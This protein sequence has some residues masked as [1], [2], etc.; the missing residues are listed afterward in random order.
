MDTPTELGPYRLLE[1]IG[2]GGMGV[3]WKA[4]HRDTGELAAV[5]TVR[6][7]SAALIETIRREVHALSQL[8]HPGIVRVRESGVRLDEPWYAMDWVDGS[9]PFAEGASTSEKIQ[10]D[11]TW[12]P[13][14]PLVDTAPTSGTAAAL[15]VALT[16][17]WRLCGP[18]AYLHG[19]GA[20]H[21]DL[22]PGNVLLRD[23]WP[24]IVDFGLVERFGGGTREALD[25]GGGRAFTPRYAAPEQLRGERVDARADLYALGVM[26]F[27]LVAGELPFDGSSSEIVDQHLHAAPPLLSSRVAGVPDPLDALVLGLLAKNPRRRLGHADDVAAELASLGADTYPWADAPQSKAYLYRPALAGRESA[28]RTLAQA[29]RAALVGE[30]GVGKTRL[31]VE[32]AQRAEARGALVVSGVGRPGGSAPF[33]LWRRPLDRLAEVCRERGE[34]FT[35]EVLAERGAVLADLRP[36]IASLRAWPP[37]P[38]LRGTAARDRR[39]DAVARTWDAFAARVPALLV[40]DDVQWADAMSIDAAARLSGGLLATWRSE[41]ASVALEPLADACETISLGPLTPDEVRAVVADMLGVAEAPE[42]FATWL[43]DRCD[44]MPFFVAEYLDLALHEGLLSRDGRGRWLLG[45]TWDSQLSELAL[46]QLPIPRGLAELA[47][48]RTDGLS[49]DARS[50]LLAAAVLAAPVP[51]DALGELVRLDGEDLLDAWAPLERRRLLAPEGDGEVGFVHDRLRE[52]LWQ[53]VPPATRAYLHRRAAALLEARSEDVLA[54]GGRIGRHREHAGQPELARTHY[55]AAGQHAA[56]RDAFAEA[57]E[58][59]EQAIALYPADDEA[60]VNL[61]Y[62]LG[63]V[64]ISLGRPKDAVTVG[65]QAQAAATARGDAHARMLARM[66][67]GQGLR[68]LGRGDDAD[69]ALE[70]ALED[71]DHASPVERAR[72][73]HL[74]ALTRFDRGR[75]DEALARTHIALDAAREADEPFLIAAIVGNQGTFAMHTGDY[76]LAIPALT[77]AVAVFRELNAPREA[78]IFL[79]NLGTVYSMRGELELALSHFEEAVAV[80]ERVGDARHAAIHGGNIALTHYESGDLDA[81]DTGFARAVAAL[82]EQ[83]DPYHLG[84]YL[85]SWALVALDQGDLDTART[86]LQASERTQATL[87]APHAAAQRHIIASA[88]A[89]A[90]GEA[91]DEHEQRVREAAAFF[92]DSGEGPGASLAWSELGLLRLARGAAADDALRRAT[93]AAEAAKVRLDGHSYVAKWLRALQGQMATR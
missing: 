7:A 85:T 52:A 11:L 12:S 87:D 75:F 6:V 26:L 70:A 55:A 63:T 73:L 31:A 1:Q 8:A 50:L 39:V 62:R 76:D 27:E 9:Q 81:A 25:L 89:R 34:A 54:D 14:E 41:E 20:V 32:A 24:V 72:L 43:A 28:L 82:E 42:P 86:R 65:E 19:E 17:I 58:L 69:A 30:G 57:A 71:A 59:L 84:L 91:L 2:A 35:D 53:E 38:P 37:A 23:G 80:A 13:D 78:G 10:A 46:E 40:L 3:V 15:D 29:P 68:M 67:L 45:G 56:D 5:K 16:R 77:E 18:L 79:G 61:R 66:A 49:G 64:Y 60:L 90:G 83:G 33:A 4:Q 48:R 44:G 74:L 93:A 88:V 22:K 21:R 47:R 36:S 51:L 92:D